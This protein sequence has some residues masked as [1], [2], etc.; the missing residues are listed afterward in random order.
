MQYSALPT[1]LSHEVLLFVYKKLQISLDLFLTSNNNKIN[2]KYC[3]SNKRNV[4]HNQWEQSYVLTLKI[5]RRALFDTLIYSS[6]NIKMN[7]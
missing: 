5:S 7:F 1:L 4:L 2:N 3:I 6:F